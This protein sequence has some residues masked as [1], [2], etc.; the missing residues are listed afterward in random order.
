M[1]KTAQR[2]RRAGR[3]GDTELVHINEHELRQLERLWGKPTINPTTGLPE[4]FNLGGFLRW[5]A[6]IVVPAAA[7]AIGGAGTL[8]SLGSFFGASPA[9][10]DTLGGAGLGGITGA[11]VNAFT[12]GDPLTGLLSGATLGGA[13][14]SVGK[15]LGFGGF[16]TPFNIPTLFNVGD[17]F[18][19]AKPAPSS[20]ADLIAGTSPDANLAGAGFTPA[21][22]AA[23]SATPAPGT[24]GGITDW[25][26]RNPWAI[27]VAAT[28][29]LSLLGGSEQE[30]AQ[31]GSAPPPARPTSWSNYR[32]P[33]FPLPRRRLTRE[34]QEANPGVYYADNRVPDV[35]ISYARGGQSQGALAMLPHYTGRLRGPGDGRSDDI[36]ARLS[37]KEYVMDAE[38]MALL[39][40]GD[41]D[42]GADKMDDFRVNLRRHKGKA[43]VRGRFSPNAKS[44]QGYL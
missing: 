5:I 44:V 1:R 24:S 32:L 25:V 22:A 29:A 36:P 16:N 42:A 8:G 28:G 31:S 15:M 35:P 18:D 19:A 3:F 6:P 14:P 34:E 30:T 13:V 11:A 9:W 7:E 23:G 10:A 12:K 40:N 26:S 2:L 4:F 20:L 37:N 33:T 43:L 17:A 27:P 38:S 41:P 39:G 21:V